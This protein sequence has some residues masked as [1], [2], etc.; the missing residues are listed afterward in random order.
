MLLLFFVLSHAKGRCYD[1]FKAVVIL[2]LGREKRISADTFSVQLLNIII[3]II[4]I[5]II[6][7]NV[8]IIII[9]QT[10]L[11]KPEASSR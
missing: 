9:I 7:I 10:D 5:I 11:F 1:Q 8:I 3:I 4:V 2:Y 6:I